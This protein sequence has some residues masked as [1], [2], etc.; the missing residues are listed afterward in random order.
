MGGWLTG[1]MTPGGSLTAPDP[2]IAYTPPSRPDVNAKIDPATDNYM[3]ANGRPKRVNDAQVHAQLDQINAPGPPQSLLPAAAKPDA[4]A[5]AQTYVE[6]I[7]KLEGSGKDPNSSA[8]GGFIDSTWLNLMHK[9]YPQ[10]AAMPNEQVLAMRSDPQLRARMVAAYGKDNG[11]VLSSAGY[12]VNSDNLRLAHWFGAGGAKTILAADP[13]TPMEKLFS[14]GVL[15]INKLE[16]KTAGD[17]L[18]QVHQQMG[19]GDLKQIWNTPLANL[20]PEL[21]TLIQGQQQ[22]AQQTADQYQTLFNQYKQTADSTPP[23]SKE[24]DEAIT[25]MRRESHQMMDMYR[26]MMQHP[27]TE[28]P[29]DAW[30]SFGSIAVMAA[31][32]GSRGAKQHLTAALGAAGEAMIAINANNHRNYESAYK[33]WQQQATMGLDLIKM[34]NDDIKQLID[35]KKLSV[36]EKLTK[37]STMQ[38]ELGMVKTL[39]DINRAPFDAA[40]DLVAKRDAAAGN[41]NTMIKQVQFQNAMAEYQRVLGETGDQAKATEAFNKSLK[42]GAP[43]TQSAGREQEIE[44]AVQAKDAQWDKDHPGATQAEKDA[45]H[46]KNRTD[47]EHDMSQATHAPRSAPAMYMQ[48]FVQEHPEADADAMA[49]AAARYRAQGAMEQAFGSGPQG[50]TIRSLNVAIDHTD[51]MSQLADALQNGDIQKVNALKNRMLVEFGHEGPVDFDI[52][53]KI[54]ADEIVKSVLGIGAGTGQERLELQADLDRANSPEQLH[55]VIQTARRLML[56]QMRGLE[57]QYAAGDPKREEFFRS[58][59]FDHTRDALESTDKGAKGAAPPAAGASPAPSSA[60]PRRTQDGNTFEQ[61]ED[62]SWKYV[63]PAQ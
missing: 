55:G 61:Q 37:L 45:A 63:G 11:A 40:V 57:Q 17:V 21:K 3:D 54:V 2:D 46:F 51:V 59:L 25:A 24:R 34:E 36:D 53:K 44:R 48:K 23:G 52:A 35:D 26:N 8:V 28:K 12:P 42:A 33:T 14:P 6:R 56:G 27:P 31:M 58:K 39:G 10:T 7:M 60:K 49:M 62:G 18:A 47:A 41:V 16:G 30:A 1:D 22:V 13:G 43:A 5:Q 32:L 19:G 20:S 38:T 15:A 4:D 50:N 29:V 9:T